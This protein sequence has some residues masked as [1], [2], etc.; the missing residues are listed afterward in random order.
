MAPKRQKGA[1]AVAR[2]GEALER[3]VVEYVN[4]ADV[5][6]NA[7]N[8][9]RQSDHDFNLLQR[10]ISEDG[11]TQPVVAI[12]INAEHR[13]DAKFERYS[14]G[15]VVIVD[16]EHRWRAAHAL[17]LTQIPVV[18]VPMSVEQMRVATLRHNRARGTEDY[19]LS[20]AVLRDLQELGAMEWASESLQISDVELESLLSEIPAPEALAD[21]EFTP[22]WEPGSETRDGLEFRDDAT[23][24]ITPEAVAAVRAA[25]R[26]AEAAATEEERAAVRRDS[27]VFRL[28]LTFSGD[29]GALVKSVLG[30]SPAVRLVEVCAAW[31]EAH[32]AE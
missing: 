20:A 29:Q 15:D 5:Q 31:V 16:G 19:E 12:R 11:F 1:A 6:A 26:R 27:D 9:N 28:V 14:D 3:L 21:P 7:Y 10:S 22:A 24:A 8:P 32:P 18:I 2:K 23:N 17:G 4:V 30:D 13:R 25:E